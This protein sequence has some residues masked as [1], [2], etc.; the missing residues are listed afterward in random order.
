[1]SSSYRDSPMKCMQRVLD[2]DMC[3]RCKQVEDILVFYYLGKKTFYGLL[4]IL[5]K[6]Y[7]DSFLHFDM[8]QKKSQILDKP[9][10]QICLLHKNV[11]KT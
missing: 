3:S 9:G 11:N 8:W 2:W 6:T 5:N 10:L 1:M 4:L 7:Y